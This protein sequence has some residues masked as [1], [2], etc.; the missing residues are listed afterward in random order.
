MKKRGIIV[1]LIGLIVLSNLVCLY[2][3]G[4]ST[5]ESISM[6]NSALL[7]LNE[8]E[9]SLLQ[10][11][12]E[13]FSVL[14]VND[15][16][17]QLEELLNAQ[18]LLKEKKKVT[19]FSL[20]LQYCKDISSVKALAFKS[21]DDLD[22]L[23][24]FYNE[25]FG[26]DINSNIINT[27][28]IDSMINEAD[29]EMKNERYEKIGPL[30]DK[31]YTEIINLKSQQTTLNL[32]YE[33]TTRSVGKI[34]Y[35][36]RYIILSVVLLLIIFFF[37][38][39]K[40]IYKWILQRKINNLE[41]RKKTL[42]DLIMKTQREYFNEGSISEGTFNIKIKKLAE[43]VRDIERQIPLL[44]EGLAKIDWENKKLDKSQKSED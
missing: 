2:A 21:R 33:T 3:E 19:D 15:T 41:L 42:K 26:L 20:V 25:S 1:L 6:E 44:Q 30:I 39:K 23:K 11:Q 40:A 32:F 27:S 17:K 14:R 24:K 37:I 35:K 22:A 13:G 18:L 12:T 29:Q 38:Y 10:L 8:S 4:L 7:C 28:K 5:N 36:N 9:Q 16:L 43:L 34:I 31:T